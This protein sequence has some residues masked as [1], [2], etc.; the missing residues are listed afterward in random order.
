MKNF[1]NGNTQ[2]VIFSFAILFL[3]LSVPNFISA[4]ELTE[5]G[6]INI[7]VEET[8]QSI[9]SYQNIIVLDV[10]NQTEY[11][12]GHVTGAIS[13]PLSEI[14]QR[15]NELTQYAYSFVYSDNDDESKAVCETLTSSGFKNIHN[16]IGG[17]DAWVNAKYPISGN[18]NCSTCPNAR[19]LP[20]EKSASSSAQKIAATGYCPSYGGSHAYEYIQNVSYSLNPGTMSITCFIY[21]TNPGNCVSGNPC[22]EYDQSPEYVNAWIDWDGDGVF[23]SGEKVIDSALI[24]YTGINYFGTMSTSTIVT[25]PPNAVSSTTMR[26][27]LGWGYDP[28][29]PCDYSWTWGDVVDQEV[30]T[31][32]VNA[33]EIEDIIITGI[34]DAKNPMTNDP[35]KDGEEKVKLEAQISSTVGYEILKVNW[36]G[37]IKSGEGNPYEYIAEPGSHGNKQVVCTIT[38]KNTS[39]GGI[40]TNTKNKTFKLFFNKIGDDDGNDLPNWFEYWKKDGPVPGMNVANYD[41]KDT[42]FGYITIFGNLYLAPR[43]AGQHYSPAIVLNNTFFG[44]ESFGGPTVRGIDCTAEV[45]AHENYHKWVDE[46]WKSGG[47]FHGKT[48]SDKDLLGLIYNDELPDF[49]ETATSH[50]KNDNTDTYDLETEKY[51]IYKKDGDQEY[52]AMRAGDG[53][54]GDANKDWANPGAQS[55]PSYGG[56]LSV[57]KLVAFSSTSYEPVQAIF[58]GSYADEGIDID[59]DGLFDYL[60]VSAEI[61][62]TTG[63]LFNIYVNADDLNT[64]EITWLNESVMLPTGT[65]TI[66]FNLL[67]LDIRQHNINGPYSISFLLYDQFGNEIDLQNNILTTASYRSTDFEEK[68]A[69]FST[70]ITEYGEDI[71]GDGLFDYLKFDVG[72]NVFSAKEYTVEGGLY[73]SS[74]N[75]IEIVKTITYLDTGYQVVT[76]TFNGLT[77][78]QNKVDGQLSL[79]Y[80]S[81]SGSP[82]IDFILD[83]HTTG[84]FN[85]SDFQSTAARLSG[86]CLD[87]GKDT[88]SDGKY[89]YL[90]AEVG[91]E[92]KDAG[93]YTLLGYLFDPNGIELQMKSNTTYLNEGTQ[94]I[95]LDYD[96]V[97]I[98]ENGV[99]GPY[100]I[101][102]L[103]LYDEDNNIMDV[104]NFSYYSIAYNFT[105]FQNPQHH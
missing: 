75:A 2:V 73:D 40:G 103:T 72:I 46:Q 100:E 71:N 16:V 5:N 79:R 7:T 77:I 42:G 9:N 39:S 57:P 22:P 66:S 44:T 3:S 90:T 64:D 78:N 35:S 45:I 36:S 51:S 89:N 47:S 80:L 49:Y 60:R 19:T 23:E 54:R 69:T 98:Y 21:I 102:Y 26:V 56:S 81:I 104:Q 29:D 105:D 95:P 34:P 74:G 86:Q 48:D 30:L 58:T 41:A 15:I 53:A 62:V 85:F 31:E 4:T 24:G 6:Y 8:M 37:D 68:D 59:G 82:Q 38:Y 18:E 96:G 84:I 43:A 12:S 88:D 1:V 94:I 61:N 55:D 65:Q 87:Y 33:P 50:T 97:T 99:N 93:K 101:K 83:A 76:L 10:R 13:I 27:N 14:E 25:I 70:N 17:I 28:N 91:I 63:G 52:M 11:E 20:P 92:V 32:D 67:G